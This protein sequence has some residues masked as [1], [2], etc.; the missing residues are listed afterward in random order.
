MY[1]KKTKSGKWYAEAY[2]GYNRQTG[3]K[4]RKV[5]IGEDLRAVKAEAS[6]WEAEHRVY[7]DSKTLAGAAEIFLQKNAELLSPSTLQGYHAILNILP[8]WLLRIPCHAITADDL[9]QYASETKVSTKTMR[10]RLAFIGVVLRQQGI[11]PPSIRLPHAEVPIL[12]IPDSDTVKKTIAAA[13]S[14]TELWVC[15]MLAATGPLRIGEIAALSLEDIDRRRNIVHVH[16]DMVRAHD[17][18]WHIK[19]PKTETSD[20]YIDM[21]PKLIE[22]I[23]EQGYVTNWNSKGIYNRFRTLL[24]KNGIPYYRFHD[25]R[26][27]C[28]SELLSQGIDEIY[29][30][31]RSGHSDYR[32]MRRYIHALGNKRRKISEK[33]LRHFDE[34]L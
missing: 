6:L 9:R 17:G 10:N 14:D 20:R 5:F 18:T 34:V 32:S 28:I 21:P 22:K 1:I 3:E 25:L 11:E 4:Y 27:F 23:F 13:E 19:T 29:V 30:A 31:E 16:H 2:A 26:H 12:N 24:R 15:I 8:D 33:I 7:H